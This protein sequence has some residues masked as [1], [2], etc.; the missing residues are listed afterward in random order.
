LGVPFIDNFNL[1]I[2]CDGGSLLKQELFPP[3]GV[4]FVPKPRR[5]SVFYSPS[6]LERGLGGEV[7]ETNITSV[8]GSLLKYKNAILRD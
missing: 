6:P 7:I 2:I 4:H 3:L 8:V 5:C 1:A